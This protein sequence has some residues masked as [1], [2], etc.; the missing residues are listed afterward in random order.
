[1]TP[2]TSDHQNQGF[3]PPQL[4]GP[5]V[6]RR[7]GFFFTFPSQVFNIKFNRQLLQETPTAPGILIT[8]F[9]WRKHT[10]ETEKIADVLRFWTVFCDFFP[11]SVN[12][13][14][15]VPVK[16]IELLTVLW[17]LNHSATLVMVRRL[18]EH[19]TLALIWISAHGLTGPTVSL[20]RTSAWYYAPWCWLTDVRKNWAEV[21]V[22]LM[23]W[24]FWLKVEA[25]F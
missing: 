25:S 9:Q 21:K 19:G 6:G 1:M 14:P 18:L 3:K 20:W 2:P 13:V 7:S 22:L 17:P 11:L 16:V 10:W 5:G 23:L 4:I 12:V 15:L 8:G 24:S